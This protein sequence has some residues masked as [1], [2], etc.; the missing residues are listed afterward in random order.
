MNGNAGIAIFLGYSLVEGG[1][2]SQLSFWLGT[3]LETL[4]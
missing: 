3:A 2:S 1:V 4:P